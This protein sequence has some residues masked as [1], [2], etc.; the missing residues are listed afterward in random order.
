MSDKWNAKKENTVPRNKSK[1]LINSGLVLFYT[2]FMLGCFLI[3]FAHRYLGDMQK[4][5]FISGFLVIVGSLCIGYVLYDLRRTLAIFSICSFLG[6]A[7]IY[8]ASVA[9]FFHSYTSYSYKYRTDKSVFKVTTSPAQLI[10][11][12]VIGVFFLNILGAIA[13]YYVAERTRK[14][15]KP[16]TLRCPDCGTWNE[17]DATHCSYCGKELKNK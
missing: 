16:L 8:I 11:M 5:S 14:G 4:W 15:E 6:F 7:L 1:W 9:L 17:Q 12:F 13:G 10:M 2:L 3:G